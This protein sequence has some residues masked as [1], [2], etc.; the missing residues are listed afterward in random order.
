MSGRPGEWMVA[1]DDPRLDR[2]RECDVHGVVCGDV[3][4]QLPRTLQKIEVGVT[5]RSMSVRSAIASSARTEETSVELDIDFRRRFVRT[6]SGDR[7]RPAPFGVTACVL[8]NYCV[9]EGGR[10]PASGRGT[11]ERVTW[12]RIS[13]KDSNARPPASDSR[14]FSTER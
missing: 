7:P 1:G 4:S 3:V 5:W 9:T 14:R 2:F 10:V 12:Q 13:S 11:I 6:L 8:R